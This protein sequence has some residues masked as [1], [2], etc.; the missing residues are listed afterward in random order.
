MRWP[1]SPSTY[2]QAGP[3]AETEDS[4]RKRK[5]HRVKKNLPRDA[6]KSHFVVLVQELGVWSAS[7]A[8]FTKLTH[9]FQRPGGYFAKVSN[10]KSARSG[11]PTFGRI[12]TS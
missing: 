11:T 2:P 5:I 4:D 9:Y 3:V 8:S 7:E 1:R 12:V 6:E 10:T